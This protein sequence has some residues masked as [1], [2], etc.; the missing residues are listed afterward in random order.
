VGAAEKPDLP[1]VFTR[2]TVK[3]V[4]RSARF[5]WYYLFPR[6]GLGCGTAQYHWDS[7]I[8]PLPV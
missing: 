2:D 8:V 4:C 1:R 7:K 5:C 6:K 3:P